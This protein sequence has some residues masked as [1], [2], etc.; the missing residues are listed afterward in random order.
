MPP[1]LVIVLCEYAPSLV[2]APCEYAP[3]LVIRLNEYAPVI[4]S[5]LFLYRLYDG[6]VLCELVNELKEDA[7]PLQV[8]CTSITI[9]WIGAQ[10]SPIILSVQQR[11]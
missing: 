4:M 7:I 10:R 9:W 2:I 3:L 11:P 8:L 1:S 5:C 6:R